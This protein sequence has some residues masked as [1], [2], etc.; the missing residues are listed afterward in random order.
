MPRAALLATLAFGCCAA[1]VVASSEHAPPL[2]TEHRADVYFHN[3]VTNEVTWTDPGVL[4]PY[5]HEPTGRFYW[6]DPV[7][8]ETTWERPDDGTGWQTHWD[9]EHR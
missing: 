3:S 9:E 8:G 2:D 1:L 5:V 6:A 4:V 7:S